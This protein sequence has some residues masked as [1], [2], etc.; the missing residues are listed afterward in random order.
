MTG[1]THVHIIHFLQGIDIAKKNK[2]CKHDEQEGTY[3]EVVSESDDSWMFRLIKSGR[4]W[5]L[6]E[7]TDGITKTVVQSF[8]NH[9]HIDESVSVDTGA[10]NTIN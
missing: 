10:S 3:T 5:L 6:T 8:F 4:C 7:H 2:H 9:S 1:K